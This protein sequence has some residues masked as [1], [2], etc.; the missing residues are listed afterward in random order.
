M[1]SRKKASFSSDAPSGDLGEDLLSLAGILW[2]AHRPMRP[3]VS[4]PKSYTNV[5]LSLREKQLH[6]KNPIVLSEP[7]LECI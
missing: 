1:T 2:F 5:L 4:V 3:E 6:E 7:L